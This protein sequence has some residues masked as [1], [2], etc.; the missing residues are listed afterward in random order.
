MIVLLGWA[1]E[2]DSD[3]TDIM[4]L[5]S[6]DE[7]IWEMESGEIINPRIDSPRNTSV[8]EPYLFSAI[9]NQD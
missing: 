4:I 9:T 6:D 5:E 3:Y 1:L 8:P 7:E 2:Q